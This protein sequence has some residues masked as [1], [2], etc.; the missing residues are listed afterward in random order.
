[1]DIAKRVF[2]EAKSTSGANYITYAGYI[3]VISSFV[4]D[5]T[6]RIGLIREVFRECCEAG[7]L[8]KLVFTQLKF[9]LTAQQYAQL[10][11]EATDE[12]TGKLRYEYTV[13]ARMAQ[14]LASSKKVIQ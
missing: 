11:E 12:K 6:K 5:I 13:N 9:S 7:Q 10:K 14:M 3:R 8:D 1:M 4:D 2:E